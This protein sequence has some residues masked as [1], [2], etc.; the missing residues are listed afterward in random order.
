ML[1]TRYLANQE[2]NFSDPQLFKPERWIQS[3][4][5]NCVFN[6]NA[7]IPFGAGPRFCAARNLAMMEM[8]M[9]IAMLCK[10]FI[11][12]RVDTGQPVEEVFSF[13]LMPKNLRVKFEK[14]H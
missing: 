9:A 6:R 14:R 3:P 1:M 10:N 4:S 13:T 12:T 2:N 5:S 7:S 11:V 8:K